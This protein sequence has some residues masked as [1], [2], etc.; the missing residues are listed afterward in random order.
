[1]ANASPERKSKAFLHS[2]EKKPVQR[3]TY[4]TIQKPVQVPFTVT[5]YVQEKKVILLPTNE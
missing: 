3:T 5:D 1:M 2:Y 4:K